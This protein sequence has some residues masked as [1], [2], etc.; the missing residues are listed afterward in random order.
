MG[1]RARSGHGRR[2][3]RGRRHGA[4]WSAAVIAVVGVCVAVYVVAG[5]GGRLPAG[6]DGAAAAASRPSAPAAAPAGTAPAGA[7][8]SAPPSASPSGPAPRAKPATPSA[9]SAKPPEAPK[10]SGSGAPSVLAPTTGTRVF[11]LVN[12]V[13]ETVWVGAGQQT[14]EPALATT[15][16][17]LPPGVTLAV[18]VPDHWNGRFWG[19]TGCSF[20]ASGRGHCETGDCDGRFQ[21]PGYG[22][23]PAS[24]AE[25]NLNAAPEGPKWP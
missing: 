5:G 25:F 2:R 19:R 22:A 13:D 12:H 4:A 20:D 21:C 1:T 8:T 24:L 7:P 23:I 17:V 16:W 3:R 18:R 14:A 11:T 15:G 6:A 10:A 9:T